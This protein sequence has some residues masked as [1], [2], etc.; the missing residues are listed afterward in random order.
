MYY[1]K[2][3]INI[4]NLVAKIIILAAL[5]PVTFIPAYILKKL[6]RG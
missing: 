2:A 3:I 4:I 5:R 1:L 6:K